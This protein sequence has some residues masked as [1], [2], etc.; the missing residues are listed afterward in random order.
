M[1][2]QEV[3]QQESVLEKAD[4]FTEGD[5]TDVTKLR[6]ELLTVGDC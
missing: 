1:F 2:T 3:A 5:Q 4:K 6:Q